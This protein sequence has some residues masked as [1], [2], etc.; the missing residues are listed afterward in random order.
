MT[1][2]R[3]ASLIWHLVVAA[4]SL[5]AATSQAQL[6][7]E[8]LQRIEAIGRRIDPQATAAILAP[9]QPPDAA[10]A[11]ITILR[12]LPYGPAERHQLDLFAPAASA[13]QVQPVLIFVHGGAFTKG[14]RRDIGPFYDNVMAW[15]VRHGMVGV[16]MTYRLAPQHVWPAGAE[17]VGLAIDWVH[18]EIGAHGGDPNRVFI[19]GH[20]AGAA[21]VA[22]YLANERLQRVQGGGLA[23]AM[24]LS[25]AY[26]ISGPPLAV[27]AYHGTDPQRYE[28]MSPLRGLTVTPVRLFVGTAQ[29]DPPPFSEQAE[30]LVNTLCRQSRCPTRA[31][32][33]GHNHMSQPFSLNS[34][35]QTVGD[36][37]LRF[38][39]LPSGLPSVLR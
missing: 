15:A 23:G 8:V 14:N 33:S 19:L 30:L 13:G 22:D 25:G 11:G 7:P 3:F 39:Q 35:D 31:V 36:A 16:N 37:L 12:D 21:H 29:W 34:D 20:S 5:F 26:R 2:V 17:D 38:M 10:L 9:R 18:R 4:T 28:E 27:A 24:F 32:F 6:P 1:T